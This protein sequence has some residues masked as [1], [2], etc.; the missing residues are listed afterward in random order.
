[1]PVSESAMVRVDARERIIFPLD[2]PTL[3]A[4]KEWVQKLDGAV[5]FFKVG[6][7]LFTATGIS[8]VPYLLEHNKEIFLDIKYYDV[9]ATVKGAVQQVAQLGVSFATVHGNSAIIKAAVEGR[10]N[11]DL[12]LLAITV[13]TSFD[14]DDLKDLGLGATSVRDLVR[15]RAQKALEAGCDGVI[16]SPQE[17]EMLRAMIA[18][19]IKPQSG[20]RFLIVTPGVRPKGSQKDDHKRHSSPAEAIKSGA[21]YLVVGRPIRESSNPNQTAQDIVRE[22]QDAFDESPRSSY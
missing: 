19:E 22:M 12:K 5:R 17:A 16:S 8:L 7:E 13:L 21:D 11:S 9:P 20:S 4:A 2:V 6:L 14:N 3:D 15:L 10:G 1:M 18:T